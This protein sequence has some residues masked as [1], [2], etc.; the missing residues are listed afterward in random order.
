[1]RNV[2]PQAEKIIGTVM[3]TSAPAEQNIQKPLVLMSLPMAVN[4]PLGSL[5]SVSFLSTTNTNAPAATR[6]ETSAMMPNVFFQ[7]TE[8]IM[9]TS[10]VVASR[11]PILPKV[12][13][14]LLARR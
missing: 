12:I 1:M 4:M 6:M 7:P 9:S 5:L 8:P 11:P 13:I 3:P 10:G 14:R 2:P